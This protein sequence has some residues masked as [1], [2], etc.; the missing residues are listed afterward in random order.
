MCTSSNLVGAK[1][2]VPTNEFT[3][4]T[5][6]SLNGV[7]IPEIKLIETDQLDNLPD[8]QLAFFIKQFDRH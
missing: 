2:E 7:D 6:A 8:E 4:M 1:K 3:A 5:L